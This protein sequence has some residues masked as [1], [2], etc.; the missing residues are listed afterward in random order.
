MKEMYRN[1]KKNK[2]CKTDMP[3]CS[4][5]GNITAHAG[6]HRDGYECKLW[7][8]KSS[9]RRGEPNNINKDAQKD[10]LVSI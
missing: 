5:P 9:E 2:E 7:G 4:I 1:V 6:R 10:S 8:L 3:F